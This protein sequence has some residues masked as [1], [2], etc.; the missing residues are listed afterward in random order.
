MGAYLP[1]GTTL[2]GR[3]FGYCV[4]LATGIREVGLATMLLHRSGQKPYSMKREE[5]RFWSA[6]ELVGALAG[7]GLHTVKKQVV[8]FWGFN[9]TR[10]RSV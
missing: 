3:S 7:S 9:N 4:R 10:P 5:E 6:S 2:L 8:P 1:R